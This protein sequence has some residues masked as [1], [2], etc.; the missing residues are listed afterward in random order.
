L[1]VAVRARATVTFVAPKV[2]F[3]APAAATYTGE[4]HVADIGVPRRLLA[5]FESSD[6]DG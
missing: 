6:R 3:S 5:P 2:G 1:G 4:V